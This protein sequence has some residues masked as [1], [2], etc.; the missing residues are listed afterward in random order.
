[1]SILRR[2]RHAPELAVITDIQFDLVK[3][4]VGIVDALHGIDFG[5]GRVVGQ[6]EEC[7]A[8][9]DREDGDSPVFFGRKAGQTTCD[10]VHEPVS[11]ALVGQVLRT[12]GQ[13]NVRE[14]G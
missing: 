14:Q 6:G 7:L 13:D 12:M 5:C 4:K 2:Q 9:V 10:H 11:A 8:V 3:R 1:M